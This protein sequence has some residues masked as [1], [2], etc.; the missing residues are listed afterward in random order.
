MN[1][2]T[3]LIFDL[4][5]GS[6]N[7]HKCQ[8]TQI[9]AIALHSRKLTVEPNGIFN[10][11]ICP[12]LDDEKAIAMGLDPLQDKALEITRKTREGLAQA[13]PLKVVWPQFVNFVNSFNYKKSSYTAPVPC[14]YNINNFDMPIVNRLCKDFKNVDKE[15]RQNLFNNIFKIDLMDMVF[16]WTENNPDIKSISLTNMC[17][18]LGLPTD[19]VDNAHDAL[20]DVKNTANILIRFLEF[21]RNIASKT[22]FEKSFAGQELR[23]K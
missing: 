12:V 13:P 14:G 20:Q 2:C 22:K 18:F 10:S 16:G 17:Q 1:N 5:T 6:A 19:T 9:A 7:P 3:Y 4:E 23:I 8:P 15:G 11:E 21:Q